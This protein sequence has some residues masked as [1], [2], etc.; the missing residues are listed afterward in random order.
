MFKLLL[1]GLFLLT[2]SQAIFAHLMV[3]QNGTLNIKDG[4]GFLAL[5]IPVKSLKEVDD[6]DNGSLSITELTKYRPLIV[7]QIDKEISLA[8]DSIT[9]PKEVAY[10]ELNSS[11]PVHYLDA[12][13][14]LVLIKF[15][16]SRNFE[17]HSLNLS[18]LN[19]T[20]NLFGLSDAEKNFH[21][22]VLNSNTKS[23]VYL[24]QEHPSVNLQ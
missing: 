20:I 9:L 22:T 19:L 12:D 14:L 17:I 24:N 3:P 23:D 1:S 7:D 5:S 2:F 11:D 13:Q 21:I 18:E 16:I 6:D 8:Y 15:T 4:F 10:L